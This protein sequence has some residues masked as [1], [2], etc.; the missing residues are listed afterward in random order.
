M[1]ESN[2]RS[3]MCPGSGKHEARSVDYE[4]GMCP[5]CDHAVRVTTTRPYEERIIN[6][7]MRVVEVHRA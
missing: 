3:E 7:H 6:R 5:V 2:E 4:A 1:Q